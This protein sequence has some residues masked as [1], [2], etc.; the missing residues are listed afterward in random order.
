MDTIEYLQNP[1][2]GE[3]VTLTFKGTGIK[4]IGCTN[5]DRGKIEVLIDGE[6][7][8]VV[9][10]YSASTVRQAEYFSKEDLT[11]GSRQQVPT[12][13]SSWMHLKSWIQHW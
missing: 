10:T 11:A 9:D 6:S 13:R 3:T 2:G 12:Q 5:K 4:V 1:N 7:Q 8:G